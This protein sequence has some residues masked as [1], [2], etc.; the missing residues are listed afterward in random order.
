MQD[1]SQQK[2]Q[3]PEPGWV[4]RPNEQTTASSTIEEV[5]VQLSNVQAPS[6]PATPQTT[7]PIVDT[8]P[9]AQN[10]VP[11]PMQSP[12]IPTPPA[13]TS[14]STQPQTLDQQQV[15]PQIAETPVISQS[16][17]FSPIYSVTEKESQVPFIENNAH[18]EWTA[19]EYL[20][21]P[22]SSGWFLLLALASVVIALIV[23]FVT[24][25]DIISTVVI[26]VIGLALGIFAARQPH[27]LNYSIDDDGLHIGQKFYPYSSFKSFS[28]VYDNALGYISLMPLKRFMPPLIIH[29][30]PNDEDKI[31][32]TLVE[33]LPLEDHKIDIV[34]N[35]AKR[36]RF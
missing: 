19:S 27:V 4:F 5:S 32:N 2:Q 1:D 15:K 10:L 23:Y 6:P 9:Q 35:I 16:A 13:Q 34:D 24:G 11:T 36:F 17:P 18:V 3:S 14:A 25:G 33:Y 12:T 20:A 22:K 29:Y 8:A 28:V 21:N 31:A 30:D 7:N 26:G